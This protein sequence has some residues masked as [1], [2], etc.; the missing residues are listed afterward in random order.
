VLHD[1]V[2][3]SSRQPLR[4]IAGGICGVRFCSM[5]SPWCMTS[6]GS[7]RAYYLSFLNARITNPV[8]DIAEF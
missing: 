7:R 8:H 6:A 5:E 1:P 2:V 4:L 3:P